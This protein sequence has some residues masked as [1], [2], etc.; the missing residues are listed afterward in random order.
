M[1]KLENTILLVEDTDSI[2]LLFK[3][4]IKKAG[5]EIIACKTGIEALEWMKNNVPVLVLLDISLPDIQGDEILKRIQAMDH[6]NDVPVVAVT[7]IA[8]EGD[9][10]K[11]LGMGFHGYIPKPIDNTGFIT[12]IQQYIKK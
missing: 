4:L 6:Y 11:Y 5:Y 2:V 8:R 1:E 9:K 10:E 7:A 3:H 12:Q